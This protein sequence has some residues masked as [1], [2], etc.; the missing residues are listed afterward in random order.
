MER[1]NF[2]KETELIKEAYEVK[3]GTDEEFMVLSES[4]SQA[5]R[6]FYLQKDFVGV[7]FTSENEQRLFNIVKTLVQEIQRTKADHVFL[8]NSEA[9]KT[10]N[11]ERALAEIWEGAVA[12]NIRVFVSESALEDYL[13]RELPEG[14]SPVSDS[15]LAL[16]FLQFE[17]ITLN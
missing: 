3:L 11:T 5:C 14:F 12:K 7:E 10:L 16:M 1:L 13:D 9:V 8:L 6:L 4:E 15:E 17:V 2:V